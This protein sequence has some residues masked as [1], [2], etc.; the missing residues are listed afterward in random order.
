[1]EELKQEFTVARRSDR[2]IGGPRGP[3]QSSGTGSLLVVEDHP[4][5][6]EALVRELG[7]LPGFRSVLAC[8]TAEEGLRLAET[9]DIRLVL[10]DIWLPG[11]S[12]IEAMPRFRRARPMAP[13]LVFSASD[14][15]REVAAAFRAGAIA[16]VSKGVPL[17][18]LGS[19]IQRARTGTI[20]EPE[21]VAPEDRGGVPDD[22]LP[23]LTHRQ[24]Q[25]IALLSRGLSNKEIAH[26]LDLAEITVKQHVSAI[27]RLLK[28]NNRTQ[29]VLATRRLGLEA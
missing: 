14:N 13:L 2:S 25:I 26:H 1:M 15:H 11:L 7:K 3:A 24:K 9:Q 17:A 12:G 10:L 6:Q 16:F 21:W 5:C 20:A 29:A 19:T 27:L 23:A 28:V 8:G 18:R 4:I 22:A